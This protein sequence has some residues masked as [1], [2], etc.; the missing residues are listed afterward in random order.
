MIK[1]GKKSTSVIISRNIIDE[2]SKFS[3]DYNPIHLDE[4]EAKNMDFQ[5]LVAHG[6]IILSMIS[7]L[8]GNEIPGPS[9]LFQI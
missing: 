9:L 8:I 7:K 3:G 5:A 4:K 6:A 1:I 2:F